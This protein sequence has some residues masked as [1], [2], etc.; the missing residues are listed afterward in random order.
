MSLS[1]LFDNHKQSFLKRDNVVMTSDT[2]ESIDQV[3]FCLLLLKQM[4]A[5]VSKGKSKRWKRDENS[6]KPL[7]SNKS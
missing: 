1:D 2:L 5:S 7:F 4:E 6:Q 3:S